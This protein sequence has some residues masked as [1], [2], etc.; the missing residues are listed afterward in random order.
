MNKKLYFGL[1]LVALLVSGCGGNTSSSVTPS[2]SNN[3]SNVVPSSTSSSASQ[4]TSSKTSTPAPSTTISTTI[5][6]SETINEYTVDF[7]VDGKS[8]HQAKVE[9]GHKVE[10]PVDP[11]KDGF[12]F[13]KW[14][15]D[16]L[17]ENAYDFDTPVTSSFSLYAEFEEDAPE[18]YT[19]TF[20][21][22]GGVL[23][24]EA[25]Q[26][27]IEGMTV[28]KPA[29]PS[30]D[31]YNFVAWTEDVE[32]NNVYDFTKLVYSS[33][34]L[35]AKYEE[36]PVEALFN[37][38]S[39][40]DESF[41]KRADFAVD[42]NTDT[43]WQ[44]KDT[45]T[46]TLTIDLEEVK[47]VSYVSQEFNDLNT[48]NFVIEGS[49][50][51]ETYA[52][53]VQNSDNTSGQKFEKAVNGFYRYIRLTVNDSGVVATSR[54]FNVVA[55]TLE[56]GT[57]VA[58]GMK[59]IADCWAGGCEPERMFDGNDGNYHCS[60]NGLHDNH[61]MGFDANKVFFV[62]YIEVL[63]AD[64]VDHKF[65]VDARLPDGSWI[66]LDGANYR[67]NSENIGVLTLEVNREI[68]A[69]LL[70]HNGN[71]TGNWPAIKEFKVFGFESYANQIA[72]EVVDNK[73]VYDMGS[74]S[75]VN[76][77]TFN[78]KEAANR[79]I[80]VSTDKE[81]WE[82]VALDNVDGE[83]IVVNKDARY[84]RYSDNSATLGADNLNIFA[85]KFETNLAMLLNPVATTRSGDAGFWE[86]MMTFNSDCA[87]AAGRFYC[88]S[89]YALEEVIT[90]DLNNPCIV[91]S[92]SYKWQDAA[93]DPVY[94]LIVEVSLDG[95]TYTTLLN[96]NEA[97]SG[98]VFVCENTEATRVVR[99]IKI[100]AQHVAG[101]TNCNTLEV[102]G[103]GST[104]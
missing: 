62:K 64:A 51:N 12:I 77:V 34:T 85:T 26:T 57:N 96:N 1:S 69:A 25:T 6:S 48:W 93:S 79:V 58:Y 11:S 19:I 37:V 15:V 16:E 2:S 100:T 47:S 70:H 91:N 10:K 82:T 17:L 66:E 30:K 23:N 22:N 60:A 94:R 83:Y 81:T 27:V 35:Y 43:Y 104:K 59:G 41:S 5:S 87:Q 61:Y 44:A 36:I 75:H 20:D 76:R 4:E 89:G 55:N 53:L 71:S 40:S 73:E 86:N 65:Y 54:E 28:T 3:V 50:D 97:T 14:C 78:N 72:H 52:V 67:E 31:G 98:H 49:L 80:E 42:G 29:D 7:I 18:E 74:L 32:G 38:T 46:Q 90:L 92:I 33:F 21:A 63:F 24:C 95:E 13:I 88:S 101:Y 9:E 99:Y 68:S 8:Y 102:M 103:Y 56:N 45:S 84:I 39:S